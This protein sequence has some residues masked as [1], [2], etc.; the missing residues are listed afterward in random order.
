MPYGRPAWTRLG[1]IFMTLSLIGLLL[2]LAKTTNLCGIPIRVTWVFHTRAAHDVIFNG[3]SKIAIVS[4]WCNGDF[5]LTN[6]RVAWNERDSGE[7]ENFMRLWKLWKIFLQ[8]YIKFTK[9]IFIVRSRYAIRFQQIN[10]LTTQNIT[11]FV[12]LC[13][14]IL[15]LV[16][17]TRMIKSKGSMPLNNFSRILIITKHWTDIKTFRT[18]TFHK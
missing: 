4:L 17:T 10:H 6:N 16:F 13:L 1:G 5:A 3:T 7:I 15:Y 9:Q 2:F 12:L 8:I 14:F 18:Y 11:F